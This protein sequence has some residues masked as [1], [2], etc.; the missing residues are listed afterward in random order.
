MNVLWILLAAFGLVVIGLYAW[1]LPR[2]GFEELYRDADPAA[3]LSLRSYRSAH[4][5]RTLRIDGTAWEYLAFGDGPETILF[6]H[7]MTGAYDIWWNQMNALAASC[8]VISLSYPAVDTLGK[9]AKGALA[10]L[11]AERVAQ[12]TVIGSSLG[13]YLA[14]YIVAT[15]P[16][17]VKRAV[18]ANTFPPNDLIASKNKSIGELLPLLPEVLV[19]KTLRGSFA[20]SVYPASGNDGLTL[21]FLNEIACGRMRKAQVLGRFKCVVEKFTPPDMA[22]LGIPVMIIEADNDPLVEPELR[23]RLKRAYPSATVHTFAGAGHFP[24]LNRPA[25]Y[26]GLLT[27]FLS[28]GTTRR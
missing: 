18:F 14:Q 28:I 10:I 26:T 4:P 15:H 20:T 13:G 8:R 21:A 9:L 11:D 17:R 6:L 27:E 23:A 5:A 12:A 1:P 3:A 19:V 7:G 25:E 22:A 24:Y 2:K 16:D